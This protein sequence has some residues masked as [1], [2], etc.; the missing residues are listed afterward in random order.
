[1]INRRLKSYDTS[2]SIYLG[3]VKVVLKLENMFTLSIVLFVLKVP[4]RKQSVVLSLN[5]AMPS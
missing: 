3:A 5:V 2:H 4:R 1:M